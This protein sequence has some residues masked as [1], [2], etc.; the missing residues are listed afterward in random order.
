MVRVHVDRAM[1]A[2]TMIE[3]RSVN[4]VEIGIWDDTVTT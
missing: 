2:A 4:M 1:D 3:I